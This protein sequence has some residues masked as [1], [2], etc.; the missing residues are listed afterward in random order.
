[1]R[2]P[3]TR[4]A[5]RHR[6]VAVFDPD[7]PPGIAFIRSLGR[8]GVPV[9]AYSADRRAGGR[10]SRFA[11]GARQCPPPSRSDDFI[12]WL[13]DEIDSGSIDLIAPTS[14]VVC[15]GVVEALEQLG[16]TSADAG[17]PPAQAVRN[18]LFKGRFVEVMRDVGFPTPPSAAPLHLA[19]AHRAAEAIGYPLVLKPRSHVG[20][21]TIRGA[22]VRCPEEL[23][24]GFVPYVIDRGNSYALGHVPELHWPL[25]QRYHDP[26]TVQVISV[27]GLLD[28]D[29]D[30]VALTH[31]RKVSQSPRRF[32][33]GTMFEPAPT[34]PFSQAAVDAV[35]GVVGS[36]LFEL[37]VLVD[38]ASGE[39]WA[40]DLNPR[41]YGQMSLDIALGFDLPRLWYE[42]VTR[43]RLPAAPP[44]SRPPA[45]W[46]E[47][48]SSY[49][50]LLVRILSGPERA[51]I[52][53]HAAGRV[54]RPK[55][56]AAFDWR[57]PLPGLLFGLAHLRH[58]RAL[59]RPFVRDIE[60]GPDVR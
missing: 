36:G 28:E 22:V 15:F 8:A 48:V 4:F 37:E 9:T 45:F 38:K 10:H 26:A 53:S 25:L 41:G 49:V 5:D 7:L 33:V 29:G 13:V 6:S 54:R 18:S 23:T 16:R 1:M 14:D 42:S 46:H 31:S 56:G 55:V 50:G 52:L 57:D 20:I 51:R 40:I 12:A 24:T 35:R 11:T 19:D 47:G 58:P 43:R 59:V 44:R 39:Y 3:T 2:L 27:C 17:H 32:G 30:V 34:P 21:G 60:L